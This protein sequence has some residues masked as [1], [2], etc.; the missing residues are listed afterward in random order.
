MP[1]LSFRHCVPED[2]DLAV[3]LI[4][5]SGPAAFDYVFCERRPDQAQAYLRQE[6]VRGKSEFGF[7]QHIAVLLDGE[8]IG[9]GAVRS[10]KQTTGFMLAA[11]HS[12]YQFYPL[13]ACAGVIARGLA[14]ERV[15]RPP[16]QNVGILYHLGIAPQHQGKGYGK[17]LV[18]ELLL[19]VK[20]RGLSIAG[21]DVAV[22]N[23]GAKSLY[24]KMGFVERATYRSSLESAFGNVVDHIYMELPLN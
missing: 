2:V 16:Q 3:P 13:L 24:T 7:Q 4:Y 22:T 5:S 17:R 23:P 14:I 12:F 18:A 15:I 8:L 6:F 11:V 20:E 1:E 21:L 9:V 10:A 19:K